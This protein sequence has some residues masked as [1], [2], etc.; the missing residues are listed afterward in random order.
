MFF[1]GVVSTELDFTLE[2]RQNHTFE[3]PLFI[4]SKILELRPTTICQPS[5]RLSAQNTAHILAENRV[6]TKRSFGIHT[7]LEKTEAF[8]NNKSSPY[9][10]FSLREAPTVAIFGLFCC[11]KS[12]LSCHSDSAVF[13]HDNEQELPSKRDSA[14]VVG[15]S[16]HIQQN[17]I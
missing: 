11:T 6:T 16:G 3:G 7:F 15:S 8:E 12:N 4:E 1:L 5:S 2:P 9:K 10:N 17:P 14:N 13:D